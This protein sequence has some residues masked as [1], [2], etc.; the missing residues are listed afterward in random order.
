MQPSKQNLADYLEYW[1]NAAQ[2]NLAPKT[3]ERYKQLVDVNIKPKLGVINLVKLQP[4]QLAQSYAWSARSG[5]RRTGK[6]LSPRTILHLPPTTAQGAAT[7]SRLAVP[8]HKP[9]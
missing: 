6:G 5:N 2:P 8:R 3:F 4:A 1:L 7:S 9:G